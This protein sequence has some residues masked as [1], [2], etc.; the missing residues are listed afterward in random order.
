MIIR[1]TNTHIICIEQDHHAHIAKQVLSQW[2]QFFLKDDPLASSVLYAIKQHD[3]GWR[4]FDKQPLWNDDT[5]MPY[6][7]ID[8]PIPIKTVLYTYGVDLVEKR[9]P[10]AAALCS[11]HYTKFLQKYK[12]KEVQQ[13]VNDEQL[14]R[15]TILQSY[16]EVDDKTFA[17]HLSLLQ[18]ADNMSLFLCLHEPGD[19][20]NKHRYFQKGI[21]IPP[22]IDYQNLQFIKTIWQNNNTIE[23]TNIEQIDDFSISL[24]ERK[25]KKSNLGNNSF[26]SIYKQT[27]PEY[28]TIH[29]RST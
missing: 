4:P 6:T 1:K 5:E 22:T 7:F 18:L 17:K 10:Y 15:S 26:I 3:L 21:Y 16:P 14:R 12:I 29:I 28:R 20:T 27:D 13:Y 25:I 19:N 9:N 23:L 11:A 24:G 2:K 8:L